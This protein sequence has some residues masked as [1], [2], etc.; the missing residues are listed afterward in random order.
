MVYGFLHCLLVAAC[1]LTRQLWIK[2]ARQSTEGATRNGRF[3]VEV[4]VIRNRMVT[5]TQ[6]VRFIQVQAV[7]VT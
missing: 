4:C 6:D 1:W 7:S 5:E 2:D 3:L